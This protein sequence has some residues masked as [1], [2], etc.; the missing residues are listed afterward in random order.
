M[1]QI[2]ILPEARFTVICLKTAIYIYSKNSR[3]LF[4]IVPCSS[5]VISSAIYRRFADSLVLAYL[6]LDDPAET[7]HVH[8]YSFNATT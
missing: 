1:S 7:V 4:D 3:D 8:D 2:E 5:P 6:S